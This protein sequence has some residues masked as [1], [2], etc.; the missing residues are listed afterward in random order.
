MK[1]KEVIKALEELSPDEEICVLW[2]ERENFSDLP[3]ETWNKLCEIFDKSDSVGDDVSLT[4]VQ[5]LTDLE[6]ETN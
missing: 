5:T 2:W 3:V 1:V 6:S 4:I